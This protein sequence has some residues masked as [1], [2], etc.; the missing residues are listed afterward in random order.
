MLLLQKFEIV[1]EKIR[2]WRAALIS[3]SHFG[4]LHLTDSV[5]VV[6]YVAHAHNAAGQE[7]DSLTCRPR[8]RWDDP[9]NKFKP[10]HE[11]VMNLVQGGKMAQKNLFLRHAQTRCRSN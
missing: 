2:A 5:N 7:D 3:A 1:T 6:V 4:S 8:P 11:G 10:G 9:V